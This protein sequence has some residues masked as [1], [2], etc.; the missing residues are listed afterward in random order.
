MKRWYVTMNW[1]DYPE[2]GSYGT[3]VECETWD[4]AQEL[5]RLEMAQAMCEECDPAD[6]DGKPEYWLDQYEAR[7]WNTVDCFDLDEFIERHKREDG[8]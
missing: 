1:H 4:K 2:G 3:I 5:C 8:S 6:K 7:D